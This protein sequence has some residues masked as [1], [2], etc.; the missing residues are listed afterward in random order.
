MKSDELSELRQELKELYAVIDAPSDDWYDKEIVDRIEQIIKRIHDIHK[1][2][3]IK[4][5]T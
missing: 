3:A 5:A 4:K 1:R 2:T